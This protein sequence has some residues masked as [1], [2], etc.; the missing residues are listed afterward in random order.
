MKENTKTFQGQKDDLDENCDSGVK[1]TQTELVLRYMKENGSINPLDALQHIGCLRLSARIHQLRASGYI[2]N[3]KRI[4]K[5]GRFG[6]ISFA[7][8]SLSKAD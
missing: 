3:S 8:Y 6:R 5:Q 2:I 1:Y 4:K 7:E